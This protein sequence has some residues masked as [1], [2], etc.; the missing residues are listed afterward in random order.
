MPRLREVWYFAKTRSKN[1]L[2][3]AGNDAETHL[4]AIVAVAGQIGRQE[5][6]FFHSPDHN[7]ANN[8]QGKGQRHPEPRATGTAR[9]M[10]LAPEYMG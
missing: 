1:A 5:F 7:N 4:L 10:R 3:K 6:F 2:P 9:S 8:G